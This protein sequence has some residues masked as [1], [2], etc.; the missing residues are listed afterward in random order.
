MER[1]AVAEAAAKKAA[2]ERAA[3]A[4]E[5][6]R[7]QVEEEEKAAKAT[8]EKAAAE[9]AAKKA[10]DEKAAGELRGR[11]RRKQED[12]LDAVE[13]FVQSVDWSAKEHAPAASVS[14]SAGIF[15]VDACA[16][17]S[18]NLNPERNIMHLRMDHNVRMPTMHGTSGR[19]S[20]DV[21]GDGFSKTT[22]SCQ[23]IGDW[24]FSR[25]RQT[26]NTCS[27]TS[28]G[29]VASHSPDN[30]DLHSNASGFSSNSEQESCKHVQVSSEEKVLHPS[31]NFQMQSSP[32]V[33]SPAGGT[34]QLDLR[35]SLG[36]PLATDGEASTDTEIPASQTPISDEQQH[37]E[38]HVDVA[39]TISTSA[40]EKRPSEGRPVEGGRTSGVRR[41]WAPSLPSQLATAAKS[42]QSSGVSFSNNLGQTRSGP[43]KSRADS[44]D[45]HDTSGGT[46]DSEGAGD[47]SPELQTG[48]D[49]STP[50]GDT[51][52]NVTR[53]VQRVWAPSSH[54]AQKPSS[55]QA[56]QPRA[57]RRVWAPSLR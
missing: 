44:K 36:M 52:M 25:A 2:E 15:V 6:V 56:A 38:E 39:N 45:D 32:N 5:A 26:P 27:S 41:V 30:E 14:D 49:S 3:E 51:S 46:Q 20:Y 40:H 7:L 33:C 48:E 13:A 55:H 37:Y 10:A 23:A 17:P 35:S 16:P 43:S 1:K 50:A 11:W 29:M 28:S 54:H 34:K 8:A 9:A 31:D 12:P 4:A 24:N 21:Q 47:I 53:K 42:R 18:Q 22:R 19:Q 57:A